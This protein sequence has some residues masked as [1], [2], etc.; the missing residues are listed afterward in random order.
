MCESVP[1]EAHG[2]E[3]TADLAL[4]E[5]ACHAGDTAL[6]AVLHAIHL[7]K[8]VLQLCALHSSPF[9]HLIPA[10]SWLVMDGGQDECRSFVLPQNAPAGHRLRLIGSECPMCSKE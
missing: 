8:H 9:I 4:L 6:Q 5:G 10:H 2:F 3:L 1:L 7:L